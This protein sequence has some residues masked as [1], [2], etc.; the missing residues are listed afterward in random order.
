[1]N[2][3]R[4]RATHLPAEERR[5]HIVEVT[6]A[7]LARHGLQGWTTATLAEAAGLSEAALFK[8]FSS[9]EQILLAALEMQADRMRE[10]I[11]EYVCE[12][13]G[14]PAVAG[15]IRHLL[16]FLETT[17]G[18]PLLIFALGPLTSTMRRKAQ[19]SMRALGDR[20][21]VLMPRSGARTDEVVAFAEAIIQSSVLRWLL[22]ETAETPLAIGEPMLVALGRLYA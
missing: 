20:I 2:R 15:L 19:A 10:A 13:R 1:M 11:D 3:R 8:H 21:L 12:S 22:R 17:H 7:L 18:G 6:L 16:R 5:A 14:W 4:T 9:K